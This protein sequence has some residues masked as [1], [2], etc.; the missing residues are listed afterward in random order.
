MIGKTVLVIDDSPEIARATARQLR[1]Y[2]NVETALTVEEALTKLPFADVALSDWDMPGGGGRKILEH[3]TIP[4]VIHSGGTLDF[5]SKDNRD[6]IRRLASGFIE[7][8]AK[9]EDLDRALYAALTGVPWT[10]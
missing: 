8:P 7:K 1:P 6:S 10:T 3:T 4:V 2:W 5:H 9:V